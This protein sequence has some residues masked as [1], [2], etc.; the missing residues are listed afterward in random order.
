MNRYF[1]TLKKAEEIYLND[2][3]LLDDNLIVKSENQNGEIFLNPILSTQGLQKNEVKEFANNC[4][5]KNKELL[6]EVYNYEIINKNI[7]IEDVI[8]Y[9]EKEKGIYYDAKKPHINKDIKLIEFGALKHT[10]LK[11]A[12]MDDYKIIMVT[13]NISN[14]Q[15]LNF[16]KNNV[17]LKSKQ[18]L[19]RIRDK[20]NNIQLGA[21]LYIYTENEKLLDECRSW[22]TEITEIDNNK[23][24]IDNKNYYLI[25]PLKINKSY[26]LLE[27]RLY[28]KLIES[29]VLVKKQRVSNDIILDTEYI[30]N[31]Y[32]DYYMVRRENIEMLLSLVN[33]IDDMPFKHLVEVYTQNREGF[34][35]NNIKDVLDIPK[36][37]LSIN[38]LNNEDYNKAYKIDVFY[39]QD[40][41][42]PIPNII[43]DGSPVEF[44]Q[45]DY[46]DEGYPIWKQ[47]FKIIQ[48]QSKIDFAESLILKGNKYFIKISDL[49]NSEEIYNKLADS[50]LLHEFIVYDNKDV[51]KTKNITYYV[52][53]PYKKEEK[54][55]YSLK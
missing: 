3:T 12:N 17:L 44:E 6:I 32:D 4:K 25:K 40:P 28:K 49:P 33:N 7:K 27:S 35:K 54:N 23:C 34:I 2:I 8:E 30:S 48:N 52:S 22:I 18:P 53:K 14:D 10:E 26:D 1:I 46:T 38:S 20:F 47:S 16:D 5:S 55:N 24:Y 15:T 50:G 45:I 42:L 19:S 51:K 13:P 41:L 29:A 9:S 31:D 37:Y 39:E 43:K 36:T 21:D 11:N